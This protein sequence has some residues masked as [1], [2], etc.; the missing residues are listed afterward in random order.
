MGGIVMEKDYIQQRLHDFINRRLQAQNTI[1]AMME[2]R[3]LSI[4]INK[5]QVILQFPV[6]KWQLNPAGHMHGGMLSTAMDIT[7]G[8]ASYIFSDASFTPTIQMSVN[9][10]KGI[11]EHETLVIEGYCDHVGSRIVQA[12]AIAHFFDS[13]A[14]VATA[15]GSYAVNHRQN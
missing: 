6:Q 3:V 10:D 15:N 8:C 9:F 14:L 11:A 7:M 4:N 1:N 12:R 13:N 5:K 2:M